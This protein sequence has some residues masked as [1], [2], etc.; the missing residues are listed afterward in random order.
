MAFIPTIIKPTRTHAA[1]PALDFSRA[2]KN[3]RKGIE[4]TVVLDLN[5]LSKMNEVVLNPNEYESSGLKPVVSMFNKLP[6]VLSPGF[7]LGEA[8]DA[9][10]DA[11]WNSWEV[12]LSRYCPTYGDTPN[13]TKDKN[14]HGRGRK[15]E[16]LPDG[17]RHMQSIAYLAILAIHVI[18][19]RD[20]HLSPEGKF[21]AYVDFMCSRAD[22]LSAVEAEVA[23]YCF[24]DRTTEKNIAFRN[25]SETIRKNFMKGGVPEI[26][27][28][29]ALNSARDINY[30]RVVATC[31]NEELDGKIQ[32][33]WLLTADEG[34]KNLTQS[35]YFV[36]GFDGSDSKAVKLVRNQ[37]Q[38]ASAYWQFCDEL[39]ADRVVQRNGWG[40]GTR[41]PGWSESHFQQI[42]DCITEQEDYV[43][44][45]YV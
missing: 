12:F 34:L 40:G 43:R 20:E 24:F 25:F 36:P 45:L 21:E 17:D 14:N 27:L 44:A 39:F 19:K 30:Y 16:R 6:I 13:A 38:K 8:D 37:S 11:L 41:E 18:A 4:T 9:Y 5:I 15:F 33:T 26:R 10:A 1:L 35:I 32:D 42:F 7:A 3:S 31:S 23:R 28:E 29:K 22:M 2:A